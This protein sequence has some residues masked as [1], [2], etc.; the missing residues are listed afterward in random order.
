MAKLRPGKNVRCVA[1]YPL[2][3]LLA[4]AVVFWPFWREG[5]TF[6]YYFAGQERDG[7]T[8]HYTA[9]VYIGRYLRE[10]ASGLFRGEFTLKHF[11]FTLLTLNFPKLE[12]VT[13][14]PFCNALFITSNITFKQSLQSLLLKPDLSFIMFTNSFLFIYSS[15][16]IISKQT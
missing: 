3:F 2:V 13:L 12:I 5:R 11:D 8:Q 14:S 1:V 9:F 7:F 16:T 15:K 10:L 6:I 4:A